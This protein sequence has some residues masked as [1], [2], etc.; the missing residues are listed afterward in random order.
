[1]SFQ[2]RLVR[3]L[4]YIC[5]ALY[6]LMT[7]LLFTQVVLRYIFAQS[8]FWAEEASRFS[9]VW[10]IFLGAVIAACQ[11]AHTRI[12]FFVELLP[13]VPRRFVEGCAM[14]LCAVTCGA[15]AWYGITIV[16]V[17]MLATSPAMGL[18]LGYVF[19]SVPLCCAVM[20]VIM[21]FRAY[22]QFTGQTLPEDRTVEEVKS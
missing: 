2:D 8:L 20:S 9:M 21:L 4:E 11:G 13:G 16:K 14:L 7:L 6:I 15:I 22:W 17:A 1:M 5:T 10:L 18:P 3:L 19:G 12:G